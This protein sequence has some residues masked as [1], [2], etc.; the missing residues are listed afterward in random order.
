MNTARALKLKRDVVYTELYDNG[1]YIGLDLK[2][3][4]LSSQSGYFNPHV[5]YAYNKYKLVREI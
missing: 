5:A 2:G 1:A 3:P 4:Y